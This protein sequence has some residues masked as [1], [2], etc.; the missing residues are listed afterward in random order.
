[1]VASA[2]GALSLY[3][4]DH[5]TFDHIAELVGTAEHPLGGEDRIAV[6][7]VPS[8]VTRRFARP[9]E[10][11][12]VVHPIIAALDLATDRARGHQILDEWDPEDGSRA[13]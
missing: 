9:G 13:W 4:P 3:V 5:A 1:M 2:D 8:V 7:P 12:P 10:P 6:A 11:W